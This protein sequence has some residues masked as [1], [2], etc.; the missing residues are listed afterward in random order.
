MTSGASVLAERQEG[1]LSDQ[2]KKLVPLARKTLLETRHYIYDLRPLLSGESDLRA[3]AENQVKEFRTVAGT[4][5]ELSTEGEPVRL[6]VAVAA[7]AYR[8]LQEALAN[9]LKHAQ[10][11]RVDV[12]LA[13]EPGWVRLRVQD[14]GVGMQPDGVSLGYGLANM[15]ER[16]KELGGTCEISGEPGAG[17]TVSLALTVGGSDLLT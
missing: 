3:M 10:A 1:P 17:T 2:L 5:I 7:G 15:R 14:D 12:S 11:S 13:F 16:A 9:V 6:P 4:P 8:I